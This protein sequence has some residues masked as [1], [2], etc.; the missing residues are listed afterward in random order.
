MPIISPTNGNKEPKYLHF[1]KGAEYLMPNHEILTLS[2]ELEPKT[3]LFAK[4]L[5]YLTPSHE[6][7]TFSHGKRSRR[8]MASHGIHLGH[9]ASYEMHLEVFWRLEVHGQPWDSS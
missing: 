3:S 7:L 6:K 5:E 8:H 1:Q 4:E 9:M 2:H